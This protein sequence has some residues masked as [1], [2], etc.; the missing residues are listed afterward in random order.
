MFVLTQTAAQLNLNNVCAFEFG[1]LETK[2]CFKIGFVLV[3]LC[4]RFVT[5]LISK[6]S[7]EVIS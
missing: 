1:L 5:D 2:D 6:T 4:S 3:R 7:F